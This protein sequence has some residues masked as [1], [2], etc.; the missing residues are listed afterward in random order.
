MNVEIAIA[1][2]H[3]HSQCARVSV[4]EWPK[5]VNAQESFQ[6]WVDLTIPVD[7]PGCIDEFAPLDL[8]GQTEEKG[9]EEV[10]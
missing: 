9:A 8:L 5:S 4:M 10:D 3:V 1:L 2:V 6:P 7:L